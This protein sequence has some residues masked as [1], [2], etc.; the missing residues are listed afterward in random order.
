MRIMCYNNIPRKSSALTPSHRTYTYNLRYTTVR[1]KLLHNIL[2]KDLR[3][4]KYKN[5]YIPELLVNR[6]KQQQR[7]NIINKTAP[8]KVRNQMRKQ[9]HQ[10]P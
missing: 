8:F 4:N 5:L 1:R 7:G 2:L 6:D 9:T 3:K 10:S